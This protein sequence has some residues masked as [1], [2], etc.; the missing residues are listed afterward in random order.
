MHALVR[1]PS[2]AIA[3]A[4]VRE[5]VRTPDPTQ[6]RVEHRAY[7][8]ALRK[9]GVH[10]VALPEAPDLPDACFVEDQAVVRGEVAVIARSGHP[11]RR[12]EAAA[13]ADALVAY[14]RVVHMPAPATLDGGDVLVCGRTLHVGLSKRTNAHG[15]AF[16]AEVF[17][18]LGFTVAPIPVPGSELH[19]QGVCSALDDETVLLAE[20]TV[21]ADRFTGAQRV[22]ITPRREAYAANTVAVGG[23]VLVA[24]GYPETAR[25]LEDAGFAVV[26]LRMD[27]LAAADG[28]LTCLSIRW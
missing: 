14:A 8:D 24:E 20:G 7:T 4:I 10:V 19:L 27:A 23:A 18:P 17:G 21:P 6:A 12:A 3:R 13:I 2:D 15:V 16:L 25:V 22:L 9:L 28:S 5:P 11:A 26:P 1:P